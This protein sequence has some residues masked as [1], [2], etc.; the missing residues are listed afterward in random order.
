MGFP[1][2]IEEV[3]I[4]DKTRFKRC[5]ESI[6][7]VCII[8]KDLIVVN[9]AKVDRKVYGNNSQRMII[10]YC[11]I[12]I[13]NSV[14]FSESNITSNMAQRVI[15]CEAVGRSNLILLAEPYYF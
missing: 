5:D 3:I 6:A 11:I 12:I 1:Q 7:Y 10:N 4:W 8:S 9:Y 13:W 2:D 15:L 14:D